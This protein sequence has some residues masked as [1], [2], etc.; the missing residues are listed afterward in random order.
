MVLM[1]LFSLQGKVALV[2]GASRGIGKVMA[3]A[4]SEAGATVVLAARNADKLATVAESIKQAGGRA[5]PCVVELTDDRA[6]AAAVKDIVG[7][8]G[9][10]DILVNNAGIMPIQP[11]VKAKLEAWDETLN[12]N[13]RAAFALCREV[14]PHMI[15]RR[16]GRIINVSSFAGRIGRDKTQ[17]Y[18]ASKAGLEGLT[19]SLACELGPYNIT[20]NAIAPG[21]FRTDMMGPARDN[22]AL[23]E[24]YI[25]LVA[26]GRPAELDDIKGVT[27]FLASKASAFITGA[28][29]PVDGGFSNAI[30]I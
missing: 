19:R 5:E 16:Q 11:L 2:T 26:L 29:I 8:H 20:A 4:L 15:A 1:D 27:I 30:R 28:T 25:R 21:F 9:G 3:N 24:P 13:L 18:S 14:A 10:I 22:P 23:L 12:T 7:R 17:A 6:I